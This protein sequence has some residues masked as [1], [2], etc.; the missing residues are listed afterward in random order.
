V[1]TRP[2]QYAYEQRLD[3][4]LRVVRHAQQTIAAQV[5]AAIATG[6]LRT[7]DRRRLQLAAVQSTL[8]QLGMEIDQTAAALVQDAYSQG[9]DRAQQQMIGMSIHAPE[10]PGA[11]ASVSIDSVRALQDSILERLTA[12][13]QTVGRT[14][15]DVYARAG[16][17]AALRAVLGA[18]GS[19]RTAAKALHADL[20]RDRDIARAVREGGFGFVDK[21]GKRW[22]LDHYT[23][24]VVRTT[25]REAVTQGA[26]ARMASHSIDLARVSVHASSCK[27]CA[28]WESRLV[29]LDGHRT[30]YHG[31]A[32]T[33]L[34]SLPNGGPPF[35][36]QCRHSLAP[37]AAKIDAIRLELA[38]ASAG[39]M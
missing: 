4:F 18:D 3:D 15:N 19:P 5:R 25:T 24:M 11:F 34:V 22:A 32:V 17:R 10:I 6:D 36:P 33:D 31:E 39:T 35:H 13:R 12:A 30:D 8:D 27:I 28:P 7:A 1:A 14:I 20:M 23:E 26:L 37:V 2:D 38:T 21:S 29:S 16:R 9:A